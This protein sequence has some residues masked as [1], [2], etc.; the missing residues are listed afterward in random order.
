VEDL[1]VPRQ[2]GGEMRVAEQSSVDVRGQRITE[3]QMVFMLYGSANRDAEAFGES[4]DTFNVGRQPNPH[5]AFGFGEHFCMGASLARIE[6]RILF[7]EL[8]QRFSTVELAGDP[9]RLRS[10]LMRGLVHLPVTLS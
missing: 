3:G 5:V 7:D 10:S 9:E 6:A 8:L 1:D 4:A 2:Q